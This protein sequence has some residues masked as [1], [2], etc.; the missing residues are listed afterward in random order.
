MSKLKSE[1][2]SMAFI[3]AIAFSLN[4]VLAIV[5]FW[6]P[7]ETYSQLL[8]YQMGGA[9]CI[10]GSVIASRYLGLRGEHVAASGFILLGITHGISM[11]AIGFDHYIVEKGATVIMPMIPSFILIG[12]CSLFPKWLR[13]AIVLP[14]FCFI[15][16]YINVINGGKYYCFPLQIGYTCWMMLEIL[17]AFYVYKDWQKQKA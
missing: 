7:T 15:Y 12:W 1:M 13:L 10:M 17:W 9:V 11:A 6:L 3:L 16:L 14:I 8:T 4:V 5:G 2:Q